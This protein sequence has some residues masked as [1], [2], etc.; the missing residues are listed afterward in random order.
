MALELPAYFIVGQQP[1]S[2][3]RTEDG[4]SDLLGWDFDKKKMTRAAASLDDVM[5]LQP[6]L[7]VKSTAQFSEGETVQVTKRRFDSV[8]KRLKR[9]PKKKEADEVDE[10]PPSRHRGDATGRHEPDST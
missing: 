8:V 3:E 10:E 9:P 7:P 6:G 2:W 5:G 1:V 4:G